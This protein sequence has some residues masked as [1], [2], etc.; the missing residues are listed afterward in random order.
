LRD[1]GTDEEKRIF[2]YLYGNG[3]ASGPMRAVGY[4]ENVASPILSQRESEI[5]AEKYKAAEGWE[6]FALGA[7]AAILGGLSD[8][9]Y[10]LSSF[11]KGLTG[12]TSYRFR[13]VGQQISDRV[14][15][16]ETDWA[17][18]LA[19]QG[20][21]TVSA[22]IPNMA[23]SAIPVFGKVASPTLLFATASGGAYQDSINRGNGYWESVGYGVNIG[24]LELATEKIFD[25]PG[26]VGGSKVDDFFKT[27]LSNQISKL[28][29]NPTSK[30][31]L[32][33]GGYMA[34]NGGGEAFEETLSAIFE[35]QIANVDMLKYLMWVI[36]IIAVS[37]LLILIVRVINKHEDLEEQEKSP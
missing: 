21:R 9:D 12:D 6:R 37:V 13:N 3:K 28:G 2:V 30:K 18:K 7:E 35:P 33:F 31:L 11:G 32:T 4:A 24:T 10:N 29:V 23:A 27:S 22:L 1:Y 17:P 19:M 16:A 34:I 20:G 5:A 25:V 15:E 14:I 8:F 26:L 36:L